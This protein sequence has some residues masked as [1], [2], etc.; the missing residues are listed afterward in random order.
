MMSSH[1][2]VI[3]RFLKFYHFD[4]VVLAKELL[5]LTDASWLFSRLTI[6]TKKFERHHL[7]GKECFLA[8]WV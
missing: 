1:F 4:D 3:K 2:H 8:Q 7:L 5:K 6:A